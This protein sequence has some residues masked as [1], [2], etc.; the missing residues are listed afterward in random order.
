MLE[1]HLKSPITRERLRSGPAANHIGSV[2]ELGGSRRL[3]QLWVWARD[4]L[5]EVAEPRTEH[6]VIDRAA[7]LQALAS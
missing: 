3:C 4:R 5:K 1:G 7:N 2:Q 6:A